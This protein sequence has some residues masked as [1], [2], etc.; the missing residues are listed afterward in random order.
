VRDGRTIRYLVPDE[1][2]SYIERH[3]LY[4]SNGE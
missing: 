3:G 4:A 1:V 2:C